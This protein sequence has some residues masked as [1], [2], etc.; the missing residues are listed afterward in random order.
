MSEF[1]A[2]KAKT[3]AFKLDSGDEVKKAKGTK[4][5]LLKNPISFSNYVDILFSDKKLLRSQSTFQSDHHEI[6]TQK[7]NQI[8]LN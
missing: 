4:K 1:C 2:L 6:Y 7:I 5:C 8:A 3:Y